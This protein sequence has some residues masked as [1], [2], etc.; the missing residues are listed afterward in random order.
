MLYHRISP[1]Q[2]HVALRQDHQDPA[3][4]LSQLR[5][6]A[7]STEAKEPNETLGIAWHRLALARSPAEVDGLFLRIRSTISKIF[8]LQVEICGDT[9]LQSLCGEARAEKSKVI[10]GFLATQ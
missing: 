2:S 7:K 3:L 1:G 6:T 5:A 10:L 8:N 9:T 4:Q